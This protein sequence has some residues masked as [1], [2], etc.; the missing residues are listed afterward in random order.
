MIQIIKDSDDRFKT[1]D[2]K[3]V[4]PVGKAER[5]DI[6]IPLVV[7]S[8]CSGE[9]HKLLS[10]RYIING[11][12]KNAIAYHMIRADFT[13]ILGHGPS[14]FDSKVIM[15]DFYSELDQ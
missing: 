12:P 2:G 4:Q 7:L 15:V 1:L 5:K 14:L 6:E 3:F 13:Q 10:E 9:E 8:E 11:A